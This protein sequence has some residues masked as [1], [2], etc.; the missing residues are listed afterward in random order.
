MEENCHSLLLSL[1]E[2]KLSERSVSQR[3]VAQEKL[4]AC[5]VLDNQQHAICIFMLLD[6]GWNNSVA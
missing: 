1:A 6:A 3:Q 2:F 4:M 5:R